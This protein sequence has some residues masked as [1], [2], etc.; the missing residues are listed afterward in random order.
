MFD[1]RDNLLAFG[2]R[3]KQFIFGEGWFISFRSLILL[4]AFFGHSSLSFSWIAFDKRVSYLVLAFIFYNLTLWFIAFLKRERI[5]VLITLGFLMDLVFVFFLVFLTGG[6]SSP[7]IFLFYLIIPLSTYYF[8]F[9]TGLIITTSYTVVHLI[10]CFLNPL[11]AG[12]MLTMSSRVF[13]AFLIGLAVGIL[14]EKDRRDQ[15]K[16][17]VLNKDLQVKTTE[18]E[19]AY[20]DLKTI[21]R[22]LYN[23]IESIHCG[24]IAVNL[25]GEVTTWNRSMEEMFGL[26]S[27]EVSGK[28]LQEITP[29]VFNGQILDNLGQVLKGE[30]PMAHDLA[31]R[32]VGQGGQQALANIDIHQFSDSS[33]NPLGAILVVEDVTE[34]VTLERRLAQSEKLSA[35][36]KLASGLAHEI[37]SPLSVIRGYAERLMAKIDEMDSR[38]SDAERIKNQLDRITRLVRQL[39]MF[40]RHSPPQLKQVKVNGIVRSVAEI[41]ETKFQNSGIEVTLELEES[42]P[43]L[44]ADPD[45]LYQVFFNILLNAQQ[46]MEENGGTLKLSSSIYEP[47]GTA[48][49]AGSV[50]SVIPKGSAKFV[51]VVI[52]DTGAGIPSDQLKRIFEPFF[53]TK[54]VGDGTGLGLAICHGIVSEHGGWIEVE[55]KPGGGSSFRIILP[56]HPDRERWE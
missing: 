44:E 15:R 40:A 11:P 4:G 31:V 54:D 16:I 37:G 19:G 36:G 39:L 2:K 10:A 35:I 29:E 14:S 42:L 41:L 21:E 3:F 5:R 18:L 46:A 55:S 26:K 47:H 34:L 51:E 33:G 22:H 20:E 50:A 32:S 28:A 13:Y 30:I 43:P 53:T 23:I 25:R 7:F 45:Q 49:S 24:I 9:T 56:V 48:P 52:S 1:P 12:Y 17:E 8:H 27:Q 6:V 38:R